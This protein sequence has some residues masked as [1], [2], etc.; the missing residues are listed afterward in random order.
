MNTTPK[1]TG[2]ADLEQ[3][4]N[5]ARAEL[6][7]RAQGDLFL[8]GEINR[9]ETVAEID[10][11]VRSRRRRRPGVSRSA[12]ATDAVQMVMDLEKVP[13]TDLDDEGFAPGDSD[14]FADHCQRLSSGAVMFS[15]SS[16]YGR[17]SHFGG[18]P[19]RRRFVPPHPKS[20][21]TSDLRVRAGSRPISGS[22]RNPFRHNRTFG[23]LGSPSPSMRG[24]P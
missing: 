2:R 11:L 15:G 20:A 14:N 7:A 8:D 9:A 16:K 10:G 13:A 6:E 5:A 22:C 12:A 19:C 18:T 4:K 1:S 3:R 21:V 24:P 17:S 23:R